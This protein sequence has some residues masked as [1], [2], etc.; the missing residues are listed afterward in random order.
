M[1][2]T[3]VIAAVVVLILV[4]GGWF[5]MRP[6]PTIAPVVSQPTQAPVSA[7]SDDTGSPSA[8][9]TEN[10]NL[11]TVTSVGFSPKDITISAGDS[12]AWMNNDTVDHTVNSAVHPT[13]LVYP[14]LNLGEIKPGEKKSLTFP[15]AGT[16]KYHDHLNPSLFGSVTVR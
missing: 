13:H 10:K 15:K 2:R 7:Q 14:P 5:L 3:V 16:Y 9:E 1:S 12:V 11:V 4:I 6:E 8:A